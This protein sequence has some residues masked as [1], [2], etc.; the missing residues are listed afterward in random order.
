VPQQDA[1]RGIK[2]YMGICC[3][4]DILGLAPYSSA[5]RSSAVISPSSGLKI[6]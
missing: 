6:R 2:T 5:R 4:C 1:Q 3:A